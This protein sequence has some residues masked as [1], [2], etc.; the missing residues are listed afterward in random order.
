MRTGPLPLVVQQI[1]RQRLKQRRE[2]ERRQLRLTPDNADFAASIR[3]KL[4]GLWETNQYRNFCRCG[5]EDIYRT[6]RGCHS[7][8]KFKYRCCIKWCP[9]CN[10]RLTEARRKVLRYW[11]SQISQPKHLVTTMRNY[12]TLTRKSLK[13]FGKNLAKLRRAVCFSGVRGGCVS[14]EITN[15]QR[16]WHVH[17]HWLLDVRWLDMPAVSQAWASLVN[18]DFAICKVKDLRQADY[19]QEVC[20]YVVEGSELAKW[21]ADEIHQFVQAV[22]GRRMFFV[23]GQLFKLGPQILAAIKADAPP[24]AQCECGCCD[25]V[26]ESEADA[27]LNDIRRLERRRR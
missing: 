4:D 13:L 27:I 6:C 25:F 20:K 12:A 24:Q 11:T 23:F 26:F 1:V 8:E 3:D 19:L 18:Q 15:E 2:N 5:N 16:G 21:P 7:V 22:R 9:N 14:I 10:W 17:A